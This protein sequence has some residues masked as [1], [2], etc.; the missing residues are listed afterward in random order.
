[1]GT[2][3]ESFDVF[4]KNLL[5]FRRKRPVKEALADITYCL[6]SRMTHVFSIESVV[7]KFIHHDFIGREIIGS[8][9]FCCVEYLICSHKKRGLADLIAMS[10]FFEMSER[11]DC[12]DEF[13]WNDFIVL[14]AA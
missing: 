10:T 11:A 2:S 1:M 5:L 8:H 4:F 6:K 3:F 13:L 14:T 12:K 9:V 7:A